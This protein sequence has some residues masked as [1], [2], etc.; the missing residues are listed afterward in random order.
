MLIFPAALA[1]GF[2]LARLRDLVAPTRILQRLRS[3]S[4]RRVL[5]RF[6]EFETEGGRF[7]DVDGAAEL[8][9]F[10]GSFKNF[11]ISFFLILAIGAL[12]WWVNWPLGLLAVV[13]VVVVPVLHLIGEVVTGMRLG[14]GRR[15]KGEMWWIVSGYVLRAAQYALALAVLWTGA[16]ATDDQRWWSAGIAAATAVWLLDTSHV[17]SRSIERRLR[18][19]RQVPFAAETGSD[20]IVLLRSFADD[21]RAMFSPWRNVGWY[22][23]ILPRSELLEENIT[24]LLVGGDGELVA[25]GRPGEP[26]PT[27]GASRSYWTDGT[28]KSAVQRAA[29]RCRAVVLV[30]GRTKGLAWEVEQIVAMGLLGK[31][32]VLLPPDSEDGAYTRYCMVVKHLSATPP[33]LVPRHLI[34]MV[35]ALRFDD[36]VPVHYVSSGPDYAA[37]M[38][39]HVHFFGN[40]IGRVDRDAD[41]DA[42]EIVDRLSDSSLDPEE[43]KQLERIAVT[44]DAGWRPF[45]GLSQAPRVPWRLRGQW[46]LIESA[47]EAAV[48]DAD[49]NL[50]IELYTEGAELARK[51]GLAAV[52]NHAN[53][54]IADM[55]YARGEHAAADELAGTIANQVQLADVTIGG[56]HYRAADITDRALLT[57]WRIARDTHDDVRALASLREIYEHRVKAHQRERV[58]EP[59]L[60]IARHFIEGLDWANARPWAQKSLAAAR[61]TGQLATQGHA[62][63]QLAR[64]ALAESDVESAEQHVRSAE[65]AG[66]SSADQQVLS[67]ACRADALLCCLRAADLEKRGAHLAAVDWYDLAVVRTERR[68]GAADSMTELCRA[69]L[70]HARE[71]SV[72]RFKARGRRP[73]ATSVS[74]IERSY[75]QRYGIRP[76]PA[77]K[78]EGGTD[79]H[80][81][82]VTKT[83]VAHAKAISRTNPDEAQAMALRAIKQ[84]NLSE[85]AVHGGVD[86][87]D[88][89]F[90]VLLGLAEQE[91]DDDQVL[92]RL[93]ALH[94]HRRDS[95]L[96]AWQTATALDIALFLIDRD[97]QPEAEPWAA[98]AL[99]GAETTGKLHHQAAAYTLLG[100]TALARQK[101][102]QARHCGRLAAARGRIATDHGEQRAAWS[103]WV[104][105][106]SQLASDLRARGEARAAA[107]A[108]AQAFETALLWLGPVH[109]YTKDC[110]SG[111]VAATSELSSVH[112]GSTP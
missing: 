23:P 46:S 105:A 61:E 94:D 29:A 11:S 73:E 109:E 50:A 37:Y 9:R 88:A 7:Q 24:N 76:Y 83:Y 19:R 27:L 52:K 78:A 80:T 63:V 14:P 64:I 53:A 30:A 82:P 21:G 45:V 107:N 102:A 75:A 108:Y 71:Q 12:W 97:R 16:S 49:F 34:T 66:E 4:Y 10:R 72:V 40:L 36:G 38:G 8:A 3:K 112:L 5:E 85:D 25:I 87:V 98:I 6:N 90:A 106:S 99:T 65:M 84:T 100:H 35:V 74:G 59:A 31:T 1:L 67:E 103:L 28:W 18:K 54:C 70:F 86:D 91:R 93:K 79:S 57:R 56:R 26:M 51:A 68:L 89:A 77:Y 20:A 92:M 58:A 17:V 60:A 48:N 32:L 81:T 62:E 96:L 15:A 55:L 69:K 13:V 104:R 111:L 22:R 47:A 101:Y 95:G 43:A 41:Q 44:K 110:D 33:A 42:E 2:L 39:A